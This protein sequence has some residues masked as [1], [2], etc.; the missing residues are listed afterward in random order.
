MM[1]VFVG[2]QGGVYNMNYSKYIENDRVP[3]RRFLDP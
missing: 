3:P 1:L 2:F